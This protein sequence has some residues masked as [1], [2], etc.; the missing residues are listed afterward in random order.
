MNTR[1][2]SILVHGAAKSGK[3]SFSVTTPTPRLYLDVESASRFLPIRPIDWDPYASPPPAPDGT[4]DTA[5][6]QTRDWGAV[7][8]V[9]QWLESGHHHFRSLSID[10]ISELQQRYIEL[11]SGRSQLTQQ[12]WGDVYRTVS[13]L[14]RDIRDLTMHPTRPLEAIVI[15]AMTR[16][17]DGMWKPWCQGQLATV[18]P[19]LLDVCGYL[20]VEQEMDDLTGQSREVRKFLTRRTPQFEAG[21]RVDGRI[22]IVMEVQSRT[23]GVPGTDVANILNMIFGSESEPALEFEAEQA[24]VVKVTTEETPLPAEPTEEP[25]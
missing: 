24:P 11:T 19:Y 8:R 3:S 15:T 25:A 4:W 5:V 1:S 23:S 16:Q 7:Q 9:Y 17:V 6:V 18:L 13:G 12:G 2:V 10:S 14:V 21:E 20:W 22:P